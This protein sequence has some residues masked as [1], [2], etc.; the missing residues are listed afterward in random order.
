MIRCNFHLTSIFN[1]RF[2]F[3]TIAR[4]VLEKTGHVLIVENG[5]QKFA[6]DNGIP[7]LPPGSLNT[8]DSSS[9]E[10]LTYCINEKENEE[11]KWNDDENRKIECDSD[12][13][14]NRSLDGEEYCVLSSDL[15]DWDDPMILQVILDGL[16]NHKV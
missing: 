12:C 11:N 8:A 5:A 1:F 3:L 9:F 16:E 13:F 15:T 2:Q 14:I 4:K 6:L 7:I 10:S